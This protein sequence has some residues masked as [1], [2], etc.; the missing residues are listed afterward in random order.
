MDSQRGPDGGGTDSEVRT[1]TQQESERIKRRQDKVGHIIG[2]GWPC[3][4]QDEEELGTPSV[5][6]IWLQW[7]EDPLHGD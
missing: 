4:Q 2:K 7:V 3:D 6:P 1:V 5:R